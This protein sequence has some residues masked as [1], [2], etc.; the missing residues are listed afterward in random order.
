MNDD[1]GG[2]AKEEVK[3]EIEEETILMGKR[4]SWRGQV[5]RKEGNRKR[6]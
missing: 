4:E 2:S 3:K 5:D 6:S 1:D